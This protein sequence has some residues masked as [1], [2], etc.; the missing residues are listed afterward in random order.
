MNLERLRD[1]AGRDVDVYRCSDDGSFNLVPGRTLLPGDKYAILPDISIP[2]DTVLSS[3][4]VAVDESM[5][6]GESVPITKVPLETSAITQHSDGNGNDMQL[7]VDI[8]VKYSGSVLFSGTKVIQTSGGSSFSVSDCGVTN[9]QKTYPIGVVYKTGTLIVLCLRF[10][11]FFLSITLNPVFII[12]FRSAKGVLVASLLNPKEELMG[13]VSDALMIILVMFFLATAMFIWTALS[14]KENGLPDVEIFLAYLNALTIAIPPALTASLSV[15]TSI[16]VQR[17]SSKMISVSETSRVNWAGSVSVVCFDKTGTLTEDRLIF[18]KVL[19]PCLESKGVGF[20]AFGPAA[21]EL[22]VECV[23]LMATCHSLSF[24]DG[25]GAGDALEVELLRAVGWTVIPMASPSERANFTCM[26]PVD[27]DSTKDAAVVSPMVDATRLIQPNDKML[28]ILRHFEFS[29][30][31]MRSTSLVKRPNGEIVLYVKGS[32]EALQPLVDKTSIPGDYSHILHAEV[33]S[34]HRVIAMGFH[35]FGMDADETALLKLNQI[36]IE[37]QFGI[38]FLGFI[39]LS[40]GLK[41]D[42]ISTISSLKNASIHCSMITG[43]HAHTAIAVAES[44]GLLNADKPLYYLDVVDDAT[45]IAEA[46]PP[47]SPP[48]SPLVTTESKHMTQPTRAITLGNSRSAT[49]LVLVDR[50]GNKWGIGVEDFLRMLV[51][52]STTKDGFPTTQLVMNGRSLIAL[53]NEYP[54][55][56]LVY[57]RYCRVFARM[58]P[59]DKQFIVRSL[60]QNES[61][62]VLASLLRDGDTDIDCGFHMRTSLTAIK[63]KLLPI[64]NELDVAE[65]GGPDTSMFPLDEDSAQP[66]QVMFCGDGNIILSPYTYFRVIVL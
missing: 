47:T 5:L 60:I 35:S 4:R 32:P 7:P 56:M 53:Q 23:E 63:E 54:R 1:L 62:G 25:V 2:C 39:A 27:S 40:N 14:L 43:D 15:A 19:V 44:C 11:F 28:T 18:E 50:D 37:K 36:D 46:S 22:P 45:V 8:S 41:V 51:D 52:E 66:L 26:V 65:T 10:Y 38:T 9:I 59:T 33:R 13:F 21:S 48:L 29:A 24:I 57:L 3:G 42:T 12:G 6:T 30:D 58:K 61:A 16:S 64:S 31:K 17:L 34:G 55:G 20:E 49:H